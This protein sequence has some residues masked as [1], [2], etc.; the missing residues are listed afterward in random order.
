[1][2]YHYTKLQCK[3]LLVKTVRSFVSIVII[4]HNFAFCNRFCQ[5]Y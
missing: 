3:V 4:A 5:Q 1:M 2:C